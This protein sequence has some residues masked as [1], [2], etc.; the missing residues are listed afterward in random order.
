MRSLMRSRSARRSPCRLGVQGLESRWTP[1]NVTAVVSNGVLSLTAASASAAENVFLS[2]GATPGSVTVSPGMDTTVN[3]SAAPVTVTGVS[4][5]QISLK[6]GD[7]MVAANGLTLAGSLS[8][9]GGDG[10]N[11]FSITDSQIAGSLRIAYG[12]N[13]NGIDVVTINN[14]VLVGGST[15]IALGAGYSIAEVY[16]DVYLNKGL[17]VSGG[18][19]QH[20]VF[21][22]DFTVGGSLGVNLGSGQNNVIAMRGVSVLGSAKFTGGTR[23]DEVSLTDVT[24]GGGVTANLGDGTNTFT[25]DEY[26]GRIGSTTGS[27]IG[28]KLSVTTGSGAD[29]VAVGGDAPVV[30]GGPVSIRTGDEGTVGDLVSFDDTTCAAGV[31]IDLGKGID[32]VNVEWIST[33]AAETSAFAG[34]FVV[35]AGEG[36]DTILLGVAGVNTKKAN[37]GT[38]PALSG[39]AGSDTV[40]LSNFNVKGTDN[41]PLT[42][43]GFE[44]IN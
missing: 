4:G 14:N 41:A 1:A 20:N 35:K 24:I 37:F 5:V 31:S 39:G 21:L 26:L 36:T 40:Y 44:V 6:G 7:D 42:P 10:A 19:G 28:G 33:T 15:S 25:V 2:A 17:S 13:L 27:R 16:S 22:N 18:V 29:K 38:A 32:Q 30:I 43:A 11:N 23:G 8:F 12:A 3:D 34:P 9:Q